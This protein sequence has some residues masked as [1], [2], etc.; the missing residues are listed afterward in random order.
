MPILPPFTQDD[1]ERIVLEQY[2]L[3]AAARSL[4]GEMDRNFQITA[5]DGSQ[6][7]LKIAHIN[8]TIEK[9]D[10]ENQA[11]LY[12]VSRGSRGTPQVVPASNGDLILQLPGA[13]GRE[14]LARMVTYLPGRMLVKVQPHGRELLYRA[15]AFLARF[16]RN[17]AGFEHPAMHRDFLWDMTRAGEAIQ[18]HLKSVADPARRKT[19]DHFMRRFETLVQAQLAG[20]R[21]QVIQN[22]ANDYN[23]LVH[24]REISGLIDFGDMIH[25]PVVCEP[26]IAA[27]YAVLDKADPLR[28]A[29]DLVSGYHAENPL[30]DV[31]ISLLY[32]LIAC[33]LCVSA[34]TAAYRAHL[35]PARPYLQVTAEPAWQALEKWVAIHPDFAHLTFR[36][37]CGQPPAPPAQLVSQ[38]LAD[39]QD[40]LGPL[41]AGQDAAVIFDLSPPSPLAARASEGDTEGFTEVLFAEMRRAGAAVG[42][43]R[44]NEPRLIYRSDLFKVPTD[45]GPEWR[46]IHIGLDLF[47]EA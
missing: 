36:A 6:F 12:L 39:N 17:L 11:M 34:V 22:D 9:L 45:D 5:Q 24:D 43:G 46:S 37:A 42:I 35:Y 29:A 21:S 18:H 27:A 20:L 3:V 23:L 33:R 25:A 26:A 14:Y 31:E 2:G 40:A 16:D 30:S 44:Y 28:S 32:D 10:F 8:R 4:P 7:T 41:V 1:A 19:A 38:W 47:A 15:G 13:D